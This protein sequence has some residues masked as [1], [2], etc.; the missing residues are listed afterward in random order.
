[1]L[2]PG[3]VGLYGLLLGFFLVAFLV[4][5]RKWRNA[6]AKKEEIMR[7]VAMASEEASMAEVEDTSFNS[8]VPL[9]PR[10]FQCAI[11]YFPTTL[12]CSQCKAVRY[13]FVQLNAF[14]FLLFAD[15]LFAF[16]CVF[17]FLLV[18]FCWFN[19]FMES[20]CKLQF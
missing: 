5:R 2:V 13:W 9:P 17:F 3:I 20:I 4:I 7:L 6:V 15:I 16:V 19:R 18:L 1:M 12:R 10:P 14:E 8:S 11:C